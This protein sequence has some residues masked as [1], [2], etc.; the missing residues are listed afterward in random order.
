MPTVNPLTALTRL[1]AD[2][3][4]KKVGAHVPP[5]Q[6]LDALGVARDEVAHSRLLATLLDP[7]VHAGAASVLRTLLRRVAR[8]TE[9][10][11]RVSAWIRR[12]PKGW[13]GITVQREL[14]RVD[15]IADIP[16]PDGLVVGIEN[17]IDAGEGEEQLYRYQSFLRD[18]F[19]GRRALMLFLTPHGQ[20]PL[21]ARK[22]HKV[23]CLPISYGDV[24]A[25]IEAAQKVANKRDSATLELV[26]THLREEIMG[27]PNPIRD[28]VRVLWR[29]HA[30]ALR[31][32][33]E[34]RPQLKDIREAYMDGIRRRLGADAVEFRDYPEKRGE[35]REIKFWCN[36]WPTPLVFMLR[37]DDGQLSTRV[38]VWRNDYNDAPKRLKKWAAKTNAKRQGL[39]DEDFNP[40]LQM[41]AW[42]RVF[43]EEDWPTSAIL[44][45]CNSDE[46]T[47]QVAVAQ[48]LRLV[49]RLRPYVA[50][51]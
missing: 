39:I 34:H 12:L 21:T 23:P 28:A 27:E 44:P 22:K 10:P 43:V 35:L 18:R 25:S 9:T 26:A 36:D 41:S 2:N 42:R 1:Q 50:A 7:Q 8:R 3:Q 47:A 32:I 24:L 16:G 29:K 14:Y 45:V 51:Y 20:L 4:F 37:E 38:F 40:V 5:L 13:S 33:V 17:K 15:V 30:D 48:T 31:L 6:L 19:P 46:E 49:K 11:R